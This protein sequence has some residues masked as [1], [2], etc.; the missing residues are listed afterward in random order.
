MENAVVV[1][2][3]AGLLADRYHAGLS[4][5][6]RSAIQDAWLRGE[7]RIICA[8]IAFGMGTR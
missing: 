1:T 8:T 6:D 4:G 7:I 3:A 2:Q 5:D